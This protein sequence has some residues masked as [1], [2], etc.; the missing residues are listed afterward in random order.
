MPFNDCRSDV[1]ILQQVSTWLTFH[2]PIDDDRSNTVQ[3]RELFQG[4]KV[5]GGLPAVVGIVEVLVA[6]TV[7][8]F[9]VHPVFQSR[10][11]STNLVVSLEGHG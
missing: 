9:R 7:P 8:V 3:G 10:A 6:V 5:F 2:V 4:R 11:P 1:E